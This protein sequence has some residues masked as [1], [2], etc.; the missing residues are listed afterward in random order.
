[1][2]FFFIKKIRN[3]KYESWWDV[4]HRRE[5]LFSLNEKDLTQYFTPNWGCWNRTTNLGMLCFTR[6]EK[7]VRA[8]SETTKSKGSKIWQCHCVC[9]ACHCLSLSNV[10]FVVIYL[11]Y[12]PTL[13]FFFNES[14]LHYTVPVLSFFFLPFLVKLQYSSFFFVQAILV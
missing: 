1:M 12:S 13:Y 7:L 5:S 8:H 10:Y 2:I 11:Y 3:S 4:V 14:L 6:E 9:L